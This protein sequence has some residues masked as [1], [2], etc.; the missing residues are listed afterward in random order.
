LGFEVAVQDVLVMHVLQ[1]VCVCVCVCVC[2]RARVCVRVCVCMCLGSSCMY[3]SR[4][5]C[6]ALVAQGRIH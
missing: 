3:C 2:A 4:C 1:Q 6:N 5:V